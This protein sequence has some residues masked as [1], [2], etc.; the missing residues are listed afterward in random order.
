M[1]SVHRVWLTVQVV[2][3]RR[4]DRFLDLLEQPQRL[5]AHGAINGDCDRERQATITCNV[6][7]STRGPSWQTNMIWQAKNM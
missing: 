5:Q 2:I 6:R 7:R 4:P 3:D 1:L